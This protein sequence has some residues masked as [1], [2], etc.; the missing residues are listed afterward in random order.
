MA[1]R[2]T[3][4]LFPGQGSQAVGM[5]SELAAH[6]PVI[7]ETFAEASEALGFDLWSLCQEGPAATLNQTE[8]TQPAMLA[9]G[10]A[11]WRAWRAQ[12]GGEPAWLAG[13]SLGEYSAPVAANAMSFDD[14]VRLVRRRGELMQQAVAEGEGA[15]AAIIG[16]DEEALERVC[17]ASAGDEVVSCANYNAPGQIV[18]AGNAGAVARASDAALEA[19]ARR[20]LPLPVSVPSHCGLMQGAAATLREHLATITINRPSIPVIHNADV[21]T[22][23]SPDA[24]RDCLAR[25]LWQPVRWTSTIARLKANGVERVVECGPGKVLTGL[26]RR[27]DRR[28]SAVALTDPAAL[29]ALQEEWKG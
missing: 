24:I 7:L 17:A 2:N 22:H 29:A 26:N 5:L 28:M 4:L 6:S 8:N 16:M 18:I 20:A 27:I 9:A 11:T 25:Q 23:D 12:G 1:E 21:A 3:A 13:H 19:G 14:A 10:I 15:M